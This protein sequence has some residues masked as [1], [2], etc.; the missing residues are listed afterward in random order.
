[1]QPTG[2]LAPGQIP[3]NLMKFS[4]SGTSG[5][6]FPYRDQV[7]FV[8]ALPVIG[9]TKGVQ[10]VNSGTVNGPERRRRDGQGR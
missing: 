4:A 2:Q 1:M 9:L 8:L 10:Q 3:G 5:V 6:S 7:D